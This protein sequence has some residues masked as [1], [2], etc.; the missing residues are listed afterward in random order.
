MT[1][2]NKGRPATRLVG[3][4]SVR[5][6]GQ[7]FRLQEL[8]RDALSELHVEVQLALDSIK[9][10]LH[11]AKVNLARTG[12]Y[13]EPGWW[14]R[15]QWAKKSHGQVLQVIQAEMGRQRRKSRE[16]TWASQFVEVCRERLLMEV[17]QE[18]SAEAWARVARSKEGEPHDR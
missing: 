11:A 3:S 12:E 4:K 13:A 17:F 8:N 10:Q 15:T 14:S 7:V 16:R 6:R 18:Y 5:H 1:N 2:E 9:A